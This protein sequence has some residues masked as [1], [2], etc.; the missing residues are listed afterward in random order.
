[1]DNLFDK[2]GNYYDL[3]YKDKENE[4]EVD[5]IISLLKSYGNQGNTILEFGSG[6]GRHG[7]ILA[8]KGFELHGI[9]R[10]GSM[11]KS[12]K[13]I[14]GFT[15]QEGDITEVNL[16]KKFDNIISLF[17]VV[18]YLTKNKDIKK[19]FLNAN[20]HLKKEGLFI[21]DVWYSPAVNSIKPE[22]RI[23]RFSNE[24][25]SITRIAEPA[26]IVNKNVVEVN[27]TYLVTDKKKDNNLEIKEK[28][29]MR[30][31]SLPEIEFISDETGFKIIQSEEW[32]TG[33]N[34]SERT[35]GICL[36]LKKT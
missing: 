15:C 12:A 19:L 36:I 4:R 30:H 20:N 31:F 14:N 23:K 2:I 1:M 29:P 18:S 28:H 10:S 25:V 3:I 6:T 17:H 33:E 7:R 32:I 27:Y 24:E 21:F 5:Y 26:I 22:T 9:E 13:L 16:S 11:V 34:P 8:E 35:W